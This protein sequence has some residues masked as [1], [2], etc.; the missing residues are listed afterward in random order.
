[1]LKEKGPFGGD[2]DA[3]S[4]RLTFRHNFTSKRFFPKSRLWDGHYLWKRG[5]EVRRDPGRGKG[6]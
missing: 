3:I 6:E 1:M 2:S 5:F 4:H